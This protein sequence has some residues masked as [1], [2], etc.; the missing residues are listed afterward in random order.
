MPAVEKQTVGPNRARTLENAAFFSF[1]RC[2]RASG[3][4]RSGA[5]IAA[6]SPEAM[7]VLTMRLC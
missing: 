1:L 6:A 4:D 3:I 2:G 7:G 5:G